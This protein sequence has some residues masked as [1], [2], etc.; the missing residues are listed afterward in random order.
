[1][2]DITEEDLVKLEEFI[3]INS[4]DKDSPIV[5]IAQ[6]VEKLAKKNLE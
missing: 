3:K 6:L 4:N 1:M 2:D 5:W